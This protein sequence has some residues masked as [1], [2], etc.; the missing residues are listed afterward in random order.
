MAA[1][2]ALCEQEERDLHDARF[3]ELSTRD[4][5]GAVWFRGLL[6]KEGGAYFRTAVEAL[7]QPLPDDDRRAPQRKADAL[8]EIAKLALDAGLAPKR[9]GVRPHVQVSMPLETWLGLPGAPAAE[10][11]GSGPISPE[12]MRRICGDASVRRL[13]LDGESLVIDVGRERRTFSGATRRALEVR[14]R[15]CVWPGCNRPARFCQGDHIEEWRHGGETNARN[16]RLLCWFHHRLRGEGWEL[17]RIVE[18]GE[19]RWIVTP[20]RWFFPD[21]GAA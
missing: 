7:S 1:R 19:L 3:L 18:D 6:D 17:T 13:L 9:G 10:L 5:D 4:E 20:P 21:V 8:V 16:G 12:M 2:P 14:D 15:G 11:E